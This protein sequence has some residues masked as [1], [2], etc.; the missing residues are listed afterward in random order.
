MF[1]M[2]TTET[3]TTNNGST[4]MSRIDAHIESYEMSADYDRKSA[5]SHI[6]LLIADLERTKTQLDNGESVND[7]YLGRFASV[8]RV[9]GNLRDT[10]IKL[11]TMRLASRIA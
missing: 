8:T 5:A 6:E 3:T 1:I 11:E 2:T 4:T 7:D 9:F 10:E